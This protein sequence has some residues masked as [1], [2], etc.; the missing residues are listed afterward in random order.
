M[1]KLAMIAC[2]AVALMTSI[3]A[4]SGDETKGRF[5]TV[6]GIQLSNSG[7]GVIQEK[8]WEYGEAKLRDT[9][10]LGWIDVACADRGVPRSVLQDFGKRIWFNVSGPDG[11]PPSA[12]QIS[13]N[14]PSLNTGVEGETGISI[15]GLAI[16]S[17]VTPSHVCAYQVAIWMPACPPRP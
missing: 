14:D 15:K 2:T 8:L 10:L 7:A 4:A 16:Y 5:C 13:V 3:G 12:G 1:N 9:P 11:G 17:I 6:G